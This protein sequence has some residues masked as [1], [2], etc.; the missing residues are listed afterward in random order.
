M[1]TKRG[2]RGQGQAMHQTLFRFC[3]AIYRRV[4]RCFSDMFRDGQE[5]QPVSKVVEQEK[6]MQSQRYCHVNRRGEPHRMLCSSSVAVGQFPAA[7]SG[8]SPTAICPAAPI[9]ESTS[10]GIKSPETEPCPAK[11]KL[12][13]R[14][15]DYCFGR[16]DRKIQ[17][18]CAPTPITTRA[19]ASRVVKT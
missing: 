10:P 19:F 11:A 15:F 16:R 8:A 7:V 2:Q 4:R 14:R 3:P 18:A 5:C 12:L 6:K 9:S 17:P 1:G 13:C